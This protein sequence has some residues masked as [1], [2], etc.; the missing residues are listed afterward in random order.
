MKT[1]VVD[2]RILHFAARMGM[3]YFGGYACRTV[4]DTFAIRW[5]LHLPANEELS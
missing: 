3:V 2:A 4:D 5:K 1:A